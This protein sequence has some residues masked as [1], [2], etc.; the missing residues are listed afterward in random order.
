MLPL[1]PLGNLLLLI[2]SEKTDLNEKI[3]KP[4]DDEYEPDEQDLK[5]NA[6]LEGC[7]GVI[8][9]LL[10]T[11]K[12]KDD[13]KIHRGRIFR[14]RVKCMEQICSL[15]INTESCT[16]VISEEAVKKL[17]L[18]VEPHSEPYDVAWI[19]NTKLRVT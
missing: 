15:M 2:E 13:P 9:P 3:Y 1:L 11:L 4:L 8:R 14:T 5:A 10:I 6:H 18:K 19:T 16:D 12:Q 7:L 17:G